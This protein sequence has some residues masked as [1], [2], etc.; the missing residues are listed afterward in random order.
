MNLALALRLALGAIVRNKERSLL[1][2]LGIVIGVAAVIVTVS[3]GAGARASIDQQIAN[4]GSNVV[5]VIPGSSATQGAHLGLGGAATLTL[6]D[7]LAIAHLP[8]VAAATPLVTLRTQV[9]SQYGNWQ[10]QIQGAAP[11]WPFVRNWELSAGTFFSDTDV[12]TSAKV[13]VIGATVASELFPNAD[14]IGTTIAIRNVPFR[15]IGVLTTR[16]HNVFGMDQDDLIVVPY[17]ALMQRLQSSNVRADAVNTLIFSVD[18][19]TNM[20]GVTADVDALLRARHRIAPSALPDF[21]IRNT[22][23]VASVATSTALTLQILLASV[24]TVSLVV[25]GIGIMNIMLVSV[26]ERTREIGLRMAVGAPGRAILMQFLVESATLA[27][28]GGAIGVVLGVV[29]S[30]VASAIGKFAYQPDLPSIIGA[31]VFSSAVGIFFGYSPAR[32]AATLDPIVAL[33]TE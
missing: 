2:V 21:S 14:P 22:Q 24:A 30:L 7:G 18:D 27:T 17:S 10:T 25:G 13:C 8:H 19:P 5:I 3:I 28:V 12:A 16:G 15:V 4:L 20:T 32:R 6:G 11:T 26:T 33:R 1:T 23:D 29:G 9:V 31:L